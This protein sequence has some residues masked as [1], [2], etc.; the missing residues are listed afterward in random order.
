MG[1]TQHFGIMA[2]LGLAA[3]LGAGPLARAQDA[4]TTSYLV[5]QDSSDC[6][7]STVKADDPDVISGAVEVA[8]A[9]DGTVQLKVGITATPNTTYNFYLK[10]VRVLGTIQTSSEGSGMETFSLRPGE[11]HPV[12]AFDMYPDGAPPGNKYQG[13][14]VRF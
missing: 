6:Q 3:W 8:K 4:G 2:A 5:R 1:R 12:L 11:T 9:S 14:A 10:C 13:T 7:N